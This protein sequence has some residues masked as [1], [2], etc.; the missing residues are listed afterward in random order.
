MCFY[1]VSLRPGGIFGLWTVEEQDGRI[2]PS[3][4]LKRLRIGPETGIAQ[5]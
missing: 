1:H 2:L 5:A 4:D 3:R